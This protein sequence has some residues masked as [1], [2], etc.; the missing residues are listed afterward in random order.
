MSKWATAMGA[1]LAAKNLPVDVFDQVDVADRDA[2]RYDFARSHGI[3][4]A[5]RDP[6]TD[7][8]PPSCAHAH[9]NRQRRQRHV[10]VF[11]QRYGTVITVHKK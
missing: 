11:N 4:D 5:D 2:L 1:Y 3:P 10:D 7:P 6:A 9:F 8:A